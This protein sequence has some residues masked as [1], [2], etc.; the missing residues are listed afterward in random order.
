MKMLGIVAVGVVRESRKFR[1]PIYR[2]HRA[3][4]FATAQLSCYNIFYQAC[5]LVQSAV[6]RLHVVRPTVCLSVS[7]SVCL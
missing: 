2:A 7:L 1:A 4:I 6:L 5:T 3:V